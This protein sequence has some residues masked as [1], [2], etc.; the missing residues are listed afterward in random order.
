MYRPGPRNLITDVPGLSVG[1][2]TDEMV[3]SGV[4]VVLCPGGWT[5]GVDVRGGGPGVRETE[6][7]SAENGYAKAHAVTLS[8]GSVFGLGAPDGVVAAL[9]RKGE[10]LVVRP[11]APLVPIVPGA[12]L[13]DLANGGDKA[14]DLDPPYRRL[15]VEA[16]EAAGQDF[17]LG[18]FGAGRGAR[19]GLVQGGLGS[20]SLD[21]GEGVMV[22]ALAAVNPVGSVFMPDGQTFWAWPFEIDGEF[23]GRTPSG[24]AKAIEPMPDD[25]RLAGQGRLTPGANTTLAVVAVNAAL[26]PGECKRVAMMAQ[27]GLSRAIRP[28]HTPFDGDVVF[29]VA[30][31]EIDL[32]QDER[33]RRIARIGSA[34]GDCLARAI[35][36]GVYLAHG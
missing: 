8:G 23:G 24:A 32:G 4:T 6:T 16:V 27:D 14:W 33:L 34:L 19:A 31:G 36:R 25:S 11:G 21:L 12:V 10:G 13:F 15:G 30:S 35:A 22:G 29:A 18:A 28:A 1:N 5:A 9:S 3:R 7:L 20:A 17:Q 26:S 2:A